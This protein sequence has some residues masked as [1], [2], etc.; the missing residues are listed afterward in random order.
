MKFTASESN[1]IDI[2][3]SDSDGSQDLSTGNEVNLGKNCDKKFDEIFLMEPGRNGENFFCP[4]NF[5]SGRTVL[6]E[7]LA[8]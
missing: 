5:L 4:D 8:F 6:W 3:D 1:I 2:R 7:F